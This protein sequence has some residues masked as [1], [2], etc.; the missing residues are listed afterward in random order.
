MVAQAMGS[1]AMTLTPMQLSQNKRGAAPFNSLLLAPLQCSAQKCPRPLDTLTRT[2]ALLPVLCAQGMN[3]SAGSRLRLWAE[4]Q[5]ASCLHM[6][7][8]SSVSPH[9]A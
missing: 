5:R 1:S 6:G 7:G 3:T 9:L 2:H 8:L 4:M